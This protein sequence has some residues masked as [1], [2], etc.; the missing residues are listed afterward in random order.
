[1]ARW[2]DFSEPFPP[3]EK[4]CPDCGEVKPLEAFCRNKNT[5]DGR[6]CYCKLCHNARTKESVQRV[7]GGHRHYRL[8]DR[9][10]IGASEVAAL[11]E[12][13]GGTCAIC[14][15]SPAVQVD[16]SHTTNSVRSVLCDGCNGALGAFNEDQALLLRA[17]EY[18]SQWT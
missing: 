7:H 17:I 2:S 5:R 8:R 11:I 12:A 13:Q 16:H 4:R 9:Y 6:A 15:T 1:M 14:K 10:G 18:L 3:S